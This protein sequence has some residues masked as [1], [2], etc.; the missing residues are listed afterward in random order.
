M[1]GI[2][3]KIADITAQSPEAKALQKTAKKALSRN[4]K[5]LK[6]FTKKEMP[7]VVKNQQDAMK[8]LEQLSQNI[9][10]MIKK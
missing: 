6:S 5:E 9:K 2:G 3:R 7:K 1:F 4:L 8:G 10:G